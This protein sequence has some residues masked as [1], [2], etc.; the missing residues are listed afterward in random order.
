MKARREYLTLLYKVQA[1]SLLYPEASR[2]I[3]E[4]ASDTT[5][6][7]QRYCTDTRV[8]TGLQTWLYLD[9]LL[10]KS[11]LQIMSGCEK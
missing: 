1:H 6:Q 2:H 4:Q 9:Y 8:E 3:A 10:R 5:Q 7:M 11:V